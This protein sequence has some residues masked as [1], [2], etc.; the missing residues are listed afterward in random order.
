[1]SIFPTNQITRSELTPRLLAQRIL[2]A[3]TMLVHETA[4]AR[5][6]R[7]HRIVIANTAVSNQKVS[8]HHVPAR[9]TPSTA[10]ALVYDCTI[11]A[12]ST[13]VLEG[14]FYMTAGDELHAGSDGA[15]KITVSVYGEEQA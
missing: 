8:I 13:A 14:P 12:N 15:S 9:S 1:M 7:V 6:S 2:P 11:P 4:T 10:N 3:K 5:S